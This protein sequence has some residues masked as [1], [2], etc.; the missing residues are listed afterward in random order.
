MR[1]VRNLPAIDHE[2]TR[3][4][5]VQ[6]IGNIDDITKNVPLMVEPRN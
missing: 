2:K 4:K 5:L 6:I 1:T 3:D